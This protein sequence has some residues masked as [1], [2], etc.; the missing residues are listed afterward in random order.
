MFQV[1][2][3]SGKALYEIPQYE[4]TVAMVDVSDREFYVIEVF[5][6]LGGRDHA[7]FMHS[8]FGEISTKGLVLKPCE[9]Y[10]Y[11]TQMRNFMCDPKTTPGWQVDWI[12]ED[13]F[14]FIDQEQNIH[15]RYT[16]LTTQAEAHTAEAWITFSNHDGLGSYTD[17]WIPRIMV[18]RQNNAEPLSSTFVGV[19]EPY[20][21]RSAIANIRRLTLETANGTPF[22]ETNVA[23][24]IVLTD[25]RRDLIV[26]ADVE[27]PL[28]LQPAFSDT[29][30]LVQPDWGLR[31]EGELCWVR[32]RADN[33][34]EKMVLCNGKSAKIGDTVLE[35][36]APFTEAEYKRT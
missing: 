35:Q 15:L 16:D 26:M 36:H 34:V 33:S 10:G 31:L 27:N 30:V 9:E 28:G 32:K 24:E 22:P 14:G 23:V 13:R 2:R 7:K 29:K 11:E 12:I 21:G 1:I 6:V 8:H 17:T 25:G 19:I 20:E 4:R 18:R 5:R 3:V